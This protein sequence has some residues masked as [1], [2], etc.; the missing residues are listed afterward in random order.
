MTRGI[1]TIVL[2]TEETYEKELRTKLLS[3]DGLKIVTEMDEP[4]LFEN[5][6]AQF[7]GELV[8]VNLD[9]DP[10]M[11]LQYCSQ[12]IEKYEDLTFFAISEVNDAQLILKAIRMGFKEFLLRPFDDEQLLEAAERITKL[13]LNQ[14]QQGRLIS[15]FGTVGGAGST[16]IAVNLACELQQLAKRS[17]VIVDLDLFYGH[18][19]TLMDLSPQFSIADLCQTLDAIDSSMIEKALVKHD[20]G[21]SVLARP[22]HF[23]QAQS[24]SAPNITTVL[25]ALCEM[26]EYV[27]CDG[28]TRND[29]I[30]P[31]VLDIADISVMVLNM[32][33]PSVRNID[34]ILKEM[35][36]EG[37]NLERIKLVLSR[38]YNDSGT[39]T[40]EDVEGTL[41]K[42]LFEIIPEE[43][44]VVPASINT[45]QPLLK[46]APKSKT[47]EAIRSL[48]KKI[49][50]PDGE[51]QS[52]TSRFGLIARVLG[53]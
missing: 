50:N 35:E 22:A 42:K 47:R 34:R 3:V 1:R 48:A 23:A 46:S 19:A 37:Y 21:L 29:T 18:V 11:I 9:P 16:T 40:V 10:D 14:K 31:S 43:P 12:I 8:V 15:V 7:A 49:H 26:F 36:R 52:E 30:A 6:I 27:I 13:S 45:G 2:N 20:T 4:A 51:N 5:A 53:K 39:L 24:M 32:T 44:K 17:A 38:Y 41:N 25:N 33:V 28:P